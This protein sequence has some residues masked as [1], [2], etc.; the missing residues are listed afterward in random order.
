MDEAYL[1]LGTVAEVA[2]AIRSLRVRGAPAIGIAG[3]YGLV[4]GLRTTSSTAP[5]LDRARAD[6]TRIHRELLDTRPTGRNLAYAL[7]RVAGRYRA[8]LEESLDAALAADAA[9]DEAEA[10]ERDEVRACR[11]I[12]EAGLPL[13][14]PA[15]RAVLTHCNTGVL[16]TGGVGTALAP[17]YAAHENGDTPSVLA[18]ETRPVQ[19]GGRLTAW[20]LARA[21]VPVTVITDSMAAAMM[22]EGGVGIVI[23]GADAIAMNGDVANKIGT[24]G[25]AVLA[26]HHGI[27]FYVAA[28]LSTVDAGL[29]A[30]ADVPIEER[31]EREVREAGGV[32]LVPPGARV[33]N[34]AFDVTP[35]HL[36]T[37]LVTDAG[38]HRPPFGPRLDEALSRS[39]CPAPSKG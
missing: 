17:I 27:P 37:A 25:L 20:E 5:P 18:C 13:L 39:P 19:Q 3:A 30:G 23:V 6:L 24:Y 31:A 4:L 9:W 12:G 7:T 8:V 14:P 22:A 28:P 34:P 16:A 10:V 32:T 29:A 15:G 26:A 11:A 1:D 38:V 33:R 36:I 2:E 35:A 21:G